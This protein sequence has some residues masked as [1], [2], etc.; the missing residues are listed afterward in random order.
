MDRDVYLLDP[1]SSLTVNEHQKRGINCPS[2]KFSYIS[3][4]VDE[5]GQW[6]GPGT[7]ISSSCEFPGE[8]SSEILSSGA[9]TTCQISLNGY[10]WIY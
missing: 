2:T 1:I 8:I 9:P 10:L 6:A 4:Q 7:S 5:S 3:I